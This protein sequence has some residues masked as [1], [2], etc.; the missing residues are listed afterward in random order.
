MDD[1]ITVEETAKILGLS[2]RT[3]YRMLI[4]KEL[5]GTKLKREWRISRNTLSEWLE[6]KQNLKSAEFQQN[7][8]EQDYNQ[9]D[10]DLAELGESQIKAWLT[11]VV[12]ETVIEYDL[13]WLIEDQN[14]MWI[15]KGKNRAG[16]NQEIC[17]RKISQRRI[18][19][20][21]ILNSSPEL[22]EKVRPYYDE[23]NSSFKWE[24]IFNS[25]KWSESE[26]AALKF[27]YSLDEN[28]TENQKNLIRIENNI[29][30]LDIMDA[31]LNRASIKAI[32][33]I[34][35]ENSD[36][37]GGEEMVKAHRGG[38]P[39]GVG[40][41]RGGRE[42]GVNRLERGGRTLGGGARRGGREVGE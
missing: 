10:D 18:S 6:T 38:K 42:L 22:Y 39:A 32:R 28:K 37:I 2:T 20:L 11:I 24:E 27:V 15:L 40:L 12:N 7:Y 33:E 14:D 17:V 30:L 23:L 8:T 19:L 35:G 34:Y 5:P 31:N 29:E 3:I 1:L 4:S 13:G 36:Q 21:N 16:I 9:Q 41:E 25:T 26:M